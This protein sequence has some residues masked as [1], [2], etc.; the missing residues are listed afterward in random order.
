MSIKVAILFLLFYYAIS[1]AITRLRAE[2]GFPKHDVHFGGPIQMITSSVGTANLTRS[3]LGAMPLFWFISRLFLG[4]IMPHQ[5][6]GFKISDKNGMSNQRTLWSMLLGSAVGIVAALW[7][8]LHISYKVGL[9]NMPYP[10]LYAW[11]REP[12]LYLQQWLLNPTKM[13][14]HHIGLVG[15][16]FAFAL[17]LAIMRTR[18]LWWPLHPIG[19][20][21][22]GSYGM[23]FLWSCMLV[24]WVLKWFIL[25]YGGIKRYRQAAPL[26]LGL[27]LGEFS[28]VGIRTII[29]IALNL[30]RGI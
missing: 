26:F 8:L 24:S 20:A 30:P 1:T 7:I 19:Y 18:F 27:I 23:S 2:V 13:D 16:G 29:G 14:Y 11:A 9:D 22:A 10:S 25:R 12:W 3:T 6:E 17:V 21:V 4:H 15:L 5:L 28:V